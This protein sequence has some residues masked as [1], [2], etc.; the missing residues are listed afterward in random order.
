VIRVQQ[1]RQKAARLRRL[2]STPTQGDALIDQELLVLADQFEEQAA[3]REKCLK[4]S[5]ARL[6][7]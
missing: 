3:A 5:I 1:L 2:A 6:S 7:N 4:T